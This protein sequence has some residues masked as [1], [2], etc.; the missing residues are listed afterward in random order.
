MPVSPSHSAARSDAASLERW[1]LLSFCALI[2]LG[3]HLWLVLG[4]H[5]M[6]G[7]GHGGGEVRAK[8]RAHASRLQ[9][10]SLPDQPLPSRPAVARPVSSP[11]GA[12]ATADAQSIPGE[13]LP[14]AAPPVASFPRAGGWPLPDYVP[15]EQLSIRPNFLIEMSDEVFA[16]LDASESGKVVLSLLISAAG[17]V[18]EVQVESSGLSPEGTQAFVDSMQQLKLS[19]GMLDGEVVAARWRLEFNFMAVPALP[20]GMGQAGQLP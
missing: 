20:S 16:S 12:Q 11:P 6:P 17:E 14:L 9:L 5:V 8:L 4:W 3:V 7:Q 19:P 18:D 10:N 1:L 15:A 13:A 2:S